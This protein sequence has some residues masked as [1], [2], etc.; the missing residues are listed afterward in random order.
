M[1][2]LILPIEPVP[3]LPFYRLLS[4]LLRPFSLRTVL[5]AVFALQMICVVGLLGTLTLYWGT[6]P[7]ALLSLGAIGSSLVV[8]LA[9]INRILQPIAQ[10]HRAI[11]ATAEGDWQTPLPI[12]NRDE[13]G[14]L[15]WAF[16]TM[17]EKL[18]DSFSELEHLNAELQRSERRW[19]QFL[20]GIPLGIVVYDRS[21]NMVFAS[22]QA[23]ILLCLEDMPSVPSLGL[24][25][26]FIAYQSG[27]ARRYP[28]AALPIAQALRGQP[29]WADD[30]DLRPGNQPVPIE[31]ATTP[32]F[33]QAGRVEFAIAAFQDITARQQAQTLLAD[34]SQTL[35]R[36]VA[37]RTAA[38]RQAE[39]TQR[40]ILEAIPDLLVRFSGD[41]VC[42]DVMNAGA[43]ELVAEPSD[44]IGKPMGEVLP[45]EMAAERMHYI[46]LALGTGQPQVYEYRFQSAIGWRY[47][48]A[49]IVAS[50]PDEV[51]AIVRDITERKQAEAE[52]ASQRQFLQNV[53]DSI[54]SIIVVKDRQNRVQMANRAS[55][56][57]QDITPTEMVGQGEIELNPSLSVLDSD[58]HS[59]IYQ[60]VIDTQ[61]P[62]QGEQEIID[63]F[64][65]RRWYQVEISPF[66]D[67]RGT[68]TGVI[69]NCIDITDRKQMETALKAANEKLERLAT[70]DGLTHI[71]NR[72]R[73]DEYLAQEW[74]RL[75]REQQPLSLIMFDVDFFKPY[76][77]SLGHQQ[78]DEALIAISA[79]VNRAVKR[80]GDLLARYGGEEFAVVLPNTRR[81][82]AENVAKTIQKEVAAL[83][84]A[85]PRSP[86]SEYLTVSIGIASVVPTAE[87]APEELIAAA[88]A[89]LYQAKRRGRDRYW[90]RLI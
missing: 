26:T 52:V 86:V 64:G 31:M 77:D 71:P 28:S 13:L 24:D 34:Y 65:H 16:N 33:D 80:S 1:L 89:A 18:H 29:G 62:Y 2:H 38:L 5:G 85:H 55:V 79:A 47:E 6:W 69:T 17:A 63:R 81:V 58:Q 23:R 88:D 3:K 84:I 12:Q 15:A 19:R 76:N 21:G 53:I 45:A 54:S 35:E 82:G 39:A 25:D 83:Q 87:Q 32:I 74:Q 9:V 70:L 67:A 36:Q 60:Q 37:D 68:V 22:R 90:I 61:V 46:R 43:V 59:P 41:G 27:T 7:V 75:V 50:G 73:F 51:L 44:Q 10:L 78:G 66:R 14:Q 42:L 8:G 48:E 49:R 72:R 40:I 56:A 11:Q 57:L 30:I 4:R 20:D